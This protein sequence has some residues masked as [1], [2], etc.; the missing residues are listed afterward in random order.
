MEWY[1]KVEHVYGTKGK[2]IVFDL[3]G[4]KTEILKDYQYLN[5]V[6]EKAIELSGAEIRKYEEVLFDPEGITFVYILSESHCS[7]HVYE[8][9]PD[10]KE[11]GFG[12]LLGDIH[13]CGSHVDTEAAVNYIIEQLQPDP[14][15][16]YRQTIIRGVE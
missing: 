7:A 10:P 6:Y 8:T 5:Q 2:H 3:Y 14:N 15:R 1:T 9:L 12:A 4:I 13:T 11:K 16:I